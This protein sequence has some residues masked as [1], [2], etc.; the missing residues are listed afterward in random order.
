MMDNT[1]SLVK[2]D[3]TGGWIID[4]SLGDTFCLR[5]PHYTGINAIPSFDEAVELRKSFVLG[6]F[7]NYVR[8]REDFLQELRKRVT[9]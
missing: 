4:K 3:P 7:I 6:T 8:K 5:H 1:S 9:A 2:K